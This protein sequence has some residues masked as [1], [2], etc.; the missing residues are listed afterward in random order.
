MQVVREDLNVCTVKLTVTCE[1]AEVD[2]GFQ[3]AYKAA[4]KAIKVPGFRPGQ[5]PKAIIEKQ[6]NRQAL[7]ETAAEEIVNVQWK[8]AV[9]QE[10]LEPY[11]N[12]YVEITKI[13][14]AEKA[15]E[16][17]V[18]VPLKPV[19]E[20]GDYK[21]LTASRPKLDVTDEEIDAVLDGERRRRGT[22]EAVTARGAEEG[23][24]AVVNIKAEGYEGD[25]KTFMAVIGKTFPQLDAAL[26]G[27]QGEEMKSVD[28]EFP[29]DFQEAA[30]SGKKLHC[31]V[32]LRSIASIQMPDLD[33]DFAQKLKAD[34]VG[35]LRSRLRETI[36]ARKL[37]SIG[38][39][40][41]EQLMEDLVGKSKIEVPDNLWETVAN[42]RLQDLAR[43]QQQ[44][45]KSLEDYA[46]ENGMTPQEFVDAIQAEAKMFVIRAQ[47]IQEIFVKENLK[48][49]NED[50]NQELMAFALEY[51]VSAQEALDFLRKSESLQELQ[52]RAV[53]RKVMT[54]L[55]SFAQVSEVDEN[56]AGA[57]AKPAKKAA[58]KKSEDAPTSEEK[59][60][61]STKKKAE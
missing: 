38:A 29:E 46:K 18:K 22:R 37:E 45:K 53:H 44:Q 41:N 36:L 49:S 20:L 19:V 2:Q 35:E 30:W 6:V 58:A 50:L 3:R 27:M 12:P 9:E 10:K 13:D 40:V 28:L 11:I 24:S 15:C 57:A 59:P 4:A 17:W 8:R 39:Y 61:K 16:F 55:N 48:L 56:A 34:N 31:Q 23:D 1:P 25:G 5:A 43:E 54:F 26:T 60:K 47:A 51:G 7:M 14:E 32:T 52:H 33:D 42:Q 21:S